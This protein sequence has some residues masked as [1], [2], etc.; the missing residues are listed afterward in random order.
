MLFDT[1]CHLD[2]EKFDVDREAVWARAQ[3]AGV[4]MLLNPAY[5]LESSRRATA[6]A[7][8]VPQ[9]VA[10]VGVHPNDAATF[11]AT[12][13]AELRMLARA[14]GVVAIG[15]I[16]LDNHWKTVP[17]DEQERAFLAQL[18]LA[19]ELDLPVIIHSREAMPRT[20]DILEAEFAGRP[21][22]LHSF[23]GDIPEAERALACGFYIGVSGPVTYPSAT[24]TR[25]VLRMLPL[26]RIVIETDAPYLS[27]QR[28][29][30]KRNEPA[31]V[32]LVAEKIAD[33]R[34]MMMVDVAA[35]TAQ[36]ARRLFR[37]EHE[38]AT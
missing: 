35:Q 37:L 29:R 24:Q 4:S 5:S 10:A 2:T 7:A 17:A 16:G 36:N 15:E 19:H 28:H 38:S 8:R 33:I 30:G 27:P 9:I 25:D 20:L 22:V 21:L 32:R 31:Y 18:A 13:L 6:L 3:A 12:A 11:D 23:A 34:E 14:P 26:D 1:H